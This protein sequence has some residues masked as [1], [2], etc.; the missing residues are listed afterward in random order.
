MEIVNKIKRLGLGYVFERAFERIVPARIC[1]FCALAVYQVDSGK[2]AAGPFSTAVLKICDST[3]ER[4]QLAEITSGLG[5]PK[6]TIGFLATMND[7]V[8]GGLWVALGGYRDHDLGLSFLLG[9]EGAWIYSAGVDENYRRRGIYLHLMAESARSRKDAGHAAPLIGVSKLNQ[10]S[11]K[12]I[13][14]FSTLVGQVLVFRL[15]SIVWAR[16]NGDL[17]QNQSL[18]LNCNRRPIQL[19]VSETIVTT[20]RLITDVAV[21]F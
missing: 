8:A 2:L 19:K 13:Q 14:R 5:D 12:A 18:T 17:N 1:R 11:H 10:G 3:Q 15:G 4:E 21:E 9:N 7:D 20:G 16:T 6:N